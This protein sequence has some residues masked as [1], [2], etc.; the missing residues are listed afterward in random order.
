MFVYEVITVR[1]GASSAESTLNP[2]LFLL[3]IKGELGE[4]QMY[5]RKIPRIN[6]IFWWFRFFLI[7]LG[8]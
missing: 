6:K 5:F 8:C 2:F 1:A 7:C 3:H 4:F